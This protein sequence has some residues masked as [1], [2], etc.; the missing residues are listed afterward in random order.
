MAISLA[1]CLGV[2][3]KYVANLFEI[4]H[5]LLWQLHIGLFHEKKES[6]LSE[7]CQKCW[8]VEHSAGGSTV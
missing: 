6:K 4:L 3:S 5:Q 1:L 8:L 2:H 7:A